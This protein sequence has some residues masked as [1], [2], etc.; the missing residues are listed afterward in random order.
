MQV[1]ASAGKLL[2]LVRWFL[3]GEQSIKT[4]VVPT[5]I[6]VGSI[7]PSSDAKPRRAPNLIQLGSLFGEKLPRPR[8]LEV[9][10][11]GDEPR[12]C[13]PDFGLSDHGVPT[14]LSHRFLKQPVGR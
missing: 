5:N 2:V 3:R 7:K 14:L 13:A 1:S 6:S 12:G 8:G 10:A 4:S 9:L 11:A